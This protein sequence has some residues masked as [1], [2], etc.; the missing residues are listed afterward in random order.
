MG[1]SK[2]ATY[3]CSDS[4]WIIIENFENWFIKSFINEVASYEKPVLLL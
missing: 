3:G 4:G 2:G 1:G